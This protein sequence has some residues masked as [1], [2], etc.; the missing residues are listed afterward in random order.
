MDD[1]LRHHGDAELG[2]GLLD[3]AV[4]VYDGPRPPWLDTALRDS[5]DDLGAYPSARAAE[6][7]LA[8]RHDRAPDEVLATAGAAEAFSLVARLRQWRRPVVV[9]PQFTEPHA[10]LEQAGHEVTPV[11]SWD[12]TGIP[13]DADLVVVGNPTN[14][15]G[16]L[17]PARRIADLA[18]PGRVVLVDEA[19]M[20]TVPGETESLTRHPDLLVTRSLTKHWGI[21]GVRAGYL[22]GPAALV[23]EL[24]R[25]Q[26][27]WSVSTTAA[28]AMI[29]CCTPE[30][31]VEAERRAVEIADWRAVLEAGLSDLD[32]A[33]LPSATS[34]VLA[35]PG[36]GVHER[37]RA[38]G[39]AVRRADTFPGL[40]GTWIRVAVRSTPT[41]TRFL[42]TLRGCL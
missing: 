19:F 1:G 33:Y 27:A 37:L 18:R 26:V 7:A 8:A 30:A 28:A 2:D 25:G 14:P 16:A 3:L 11:V 6:A 22:L 29:A 36:A 24:R 38:A 13:E 12:L 15:T 4:N 42:D 40:D 35:R 39:V 10:A 20:D 34:F 23:A 5:L 41:T 21:P 9:H 17:H 31:L 32:V